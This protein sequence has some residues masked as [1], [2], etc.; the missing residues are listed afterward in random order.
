MGATGAVVPGWMHVVAGRELYAPLEMLK[1][2]GQGRFQNL[3]LSQIDE[4]A[5]PTVVS[6]W[7]HLMDGW[8]C[9]FPLGKLIVALE[10]T[11]LIV[12][13]VAWV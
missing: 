13:W 8:E 5:N 1:T 12:A 11:R 2:V 9:H 10:L 6:V 7:A 3:G 4:T